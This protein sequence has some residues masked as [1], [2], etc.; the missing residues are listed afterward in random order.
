M[1]NRRLPAEWEPQRLVQ[2]TFPHRQGDWAYMYEEVVDCFVHLINTT[3]HYVPVLVVCESAKDMADYFTAETKHA[4]LFAQQPSNDTWAR[5]HGAITVLEDGE[6]LLLDFTFNGW[7]QKFDAGL[8]NIISLG[9]HAQGIFRDDL[10][11]LP[12]VL[13]GGALES[14]GQGTLLTTSE[15]LLS[16]YRNPKMDKQQ[17]EDYLKEVFGLQ[18]VLWL[19][20]GYLSGDDTDSHIDT[21]ARL[22]DEQ[23]IAYVKCDD[24]EDEHYEALKEMEAQLQTFRTLKNEPYKLVALPWPDACHD[25]EG[26][27]LPA[28]Y[29]NFLITNGAVLVPTYGV[30]QDDKALAVLR[31]CFPDREVVGVNCRPLIDQHGSLHCV[32]MQYP[33]NVT[34]SWL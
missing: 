7:G 24:P 14:D 29:A 2:F 31:T 4:I 33:E 30:K 6:P 28:T 10:Q 15:C 27:R 19:D 17:I 5:D 34:I 25:E 13:E 22:C 8:D 18:Q 32:T 3:A 9:L 11:T 12:F 26:Q 23:T 16:P 1:S 20:H 21:L